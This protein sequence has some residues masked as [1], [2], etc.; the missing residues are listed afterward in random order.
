MNVICCKWFSMFSKYWNSWRKYEGLCQQPHSSNRISNGC[1]CT[2]FVSMKVQP[3]LGRGC[4]LP[5]DLWG[6]ISSTVEETQI[7]NTWGGDNIFR[8]DILESLEPASSHGERKKIKASCTYQ[9]FAHLFQEYSMP[10]DWYK[11]QGIFSE[12]IWR[13]P[14]WTIPS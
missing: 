11:A 14:D 12:L 3:Q 4:L 9:S 8:F 1:F 2:E 7:H 10:C 6:L 13:V 5:K